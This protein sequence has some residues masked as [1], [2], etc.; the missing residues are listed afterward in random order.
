VTDPQCQTEG[1]R[2]MRFR[3]SIPYLRR[4]AGVA[5]LLSALCFPGTLPA[6]E[7]MP[8]ALAVVEARIE[9][10]EDA[11]AVP[12]GYE[13][14]PGD[15][16]YFQFDISGFQIKGSEDSG[17]RRISLAYSIQL[18]DENGVLLAPAQHQQI[19][20][21]IAP[22]DKDWTPRRRASLLLPSYAVYGTCHLKL[23]VKDLLAKTQVERE[24]PFILAG[25][26]VKELP[27]LSIQN[28]RFLRSDEDGPGL[29]VVA[30]RPGDTV[31]ARFDM[32]GFHV[33]PDNAVQLSYGVLVRRPDGKVMFSQTN[34]AKE[35]LK[36]LFYPPQVVP[37]VLSVTTTS[38]LE[39]GDYV[40]SVQLRDDIEGKSAD[41][42]GKFRI[43]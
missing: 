39:H 12:P 6:Q 24:Y 15:F 1:E 29:T 43:E 35:S 31:W 22:Q 40:L 28:L 9:N 11:P 32:T 30:Y 41:I 14:L 34:A 18:E 26:R 13:F 16:L 4:E 7:E 3:N 17:P 8:K 37:G 25:R 5:L 19:E 20:E 21:D 42:S 23:I 36:G 27:Q 38:D 33:G 10:A 2:I